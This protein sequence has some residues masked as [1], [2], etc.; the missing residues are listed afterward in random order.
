MQKLLTAPA[1]IV[2]PIPDRPLPAT[3]VFYRMARQ[4]S[5]LRGFPPLWHGRCSWFYE[6]G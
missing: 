1:R 2:D 6:R 5:G 3:A 4:F